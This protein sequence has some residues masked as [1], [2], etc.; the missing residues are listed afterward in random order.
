MADVAGDKGT[1]FVNPANA[2]CV[3]AYIWSDW[4]KKQGTWGVG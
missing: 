3:P 1:N 4:G 2:A